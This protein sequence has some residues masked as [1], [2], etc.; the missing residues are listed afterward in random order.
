M[1][2][3][4]LVGCIHE[5]VPIPAFV[6]MLM[7]AIVFGL[8]IDYEVFLISRVHEAWTKTADA[9]RSVAMG[10]GSTARVITT[11]GAHHDRGLHQLRAGSRS[12]REDACHRRGRGSSHRRKRDPHD[13][14]PS[15]HVATWPQ[16]LADAEVAAPHYPQPRYRRQRTPRPR[17]PRGAGSADPDSNGAV[18]VHCSGGHTSLRA[19]HRRRLPS[20]YAEIV[21]DGADVHRVVALALPG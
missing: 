12:H 3:G 19:A 21:T 8:S 20:P 5:K 4:L 1:G 14:R 17:I 9:H 7:F 6:P 15:S 10:I 18:V 16:C 11:A 13:S 2:L